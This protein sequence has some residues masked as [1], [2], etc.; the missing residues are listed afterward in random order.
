MNSPP[1]ISSVASFPR[2]TLA[3]HWELINIFVFS[4]YACGSIHI[5]FFMVHTPTPSFS[6]WPGLLNFLWAAITSFD[7]I[8]VN[9]AALVTMLWH[10]AAVFPQTSLRERCPR[11]HLVRKSANIFQA[12][13][14]CWTTRLKRDKCNAHLWTFRSMYL[15]EFGRKESRGNTYSKFL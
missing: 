2:W 3:P 11:N 15:D 14:I 13:S 10:R 8:S 7:L 1:I 9:Y 12:L 5:L 4:L 6:A